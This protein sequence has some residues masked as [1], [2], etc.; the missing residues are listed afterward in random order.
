MNFIK[1]ISF[2]FSGSCFQVQPSLANTDHSTPPVPCSVTQTFVGKGKLTVS[3]I[4]WTACCVFSGQDNN[5][6][7]KS[8]FCQQ[9]FHTGWPF[10][11][12]NFCVPG[13]FAG[14]ALACTGAW[15][16][17]CH[18]G[19]TATVQKTVHDKY[20]GRHRDFHQAAVK[21]QWTIHTPTLKT[22]RTLKWDFTIKKDVDKINDNFNSLAP[23]KCKA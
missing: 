19:S 21:Y 3:N 20:Q 5:D 18:C 12:A 7:D 23:I 6:P 13:C 17:H 8:T 1:N 10:S 14:K 11:N 9:H 2:A 15:N 16:C 22:A 4:S